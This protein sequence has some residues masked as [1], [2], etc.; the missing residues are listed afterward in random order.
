MED[1]HP[2]LIDEI[3][4]QDENDQDQ[5]G[6]GGGW[7]DALVPGE[8]QRLVCGAKPSSPSHL[9]QPSQTLDRLWVARAA[10]V[11]SCESESMFVLA[12]SESDKIWPHQCT[13]CI[14]GSTMA[15][16]SKAEIQKYTF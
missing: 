2:D 5:E 12:A 11:S 1:T 15:L 7:A 4:G 16:W 9:S 3:C 10:G 13:M 6:K 14:L 8:Q